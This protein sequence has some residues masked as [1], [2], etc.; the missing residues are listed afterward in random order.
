MPPPF[1]SS[2]AVMRYAIDRAQ[3]GIGRVEPNPAVGAVVVDEQLNLLGAG[4]H[5]VFGGPHGEVNAL[6]DAGS[7]ARGAELYVTLEPCC[8]HGRTPPCT[9]AVI[10]AGIRS[11]VIGCEDPSPDVSGAGIAQL[12]RAGIN[13]RCGVLD[14]EARRLIAPFSRLVTT[15]M[16]WVHAKWAMTLDG[17]TATRTGHSMWISGSESRERVHRLRGRMDAIVVGSVT[18]AMDDPLL[19]ARPPGPRTPIRIVV[20]SRAALKSDS[21]MVR[22]VAAAPV[23]VAT[24]PAAPDDDVERL[25]QAGV[26]VLRLK[27]TESHHRQQVPPGD[28]HDL[29]SIRDLLQTLGTR[30]VTNVLVEGGSRLLGGF[31]D[32]RLVNE[33]HVFIAPKIIGGAAVAVAGT[34]LDRVPPESAFT[35]LLSE[36]IGDDLY[37]RGILNP[38]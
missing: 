18:A 35:E 25:E 9:E 11:V 7:A 20:D 33:V 13:V 36:Q 19:T 10:A 12:R 5:E 21:Q 16:P 6:D 28:Q 14:E 32:E 24:G 15:G 37:L 1:A 27:A 3:P 22:T 31:F 38:Q 4:H 8:R 26:E 30:D 34:G 17:H 29:V 23:L 2:E